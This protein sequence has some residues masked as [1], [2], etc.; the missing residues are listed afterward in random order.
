MTLHLDP[1]SCSTRRIGP[2]KPLRVGNKQVEQ[3]QDCGVL[4]DCIRDEFPRKREAT[5]E[6]AKIREAIFVGDDDL[7]IEER[8]EWQGVN[9]RYQFGEPGRQ[10]TTI[11]TEQLWRRV[12]TTPQLSAEPIEAWARTPSAHLGVTGR[13]AAQALDLATCSTRCQRLVDPG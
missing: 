12:S 9:C 11:A 2:I 13:R 4:V 1:I 5:L 7:T 6:G 10:V 8:G 3:K